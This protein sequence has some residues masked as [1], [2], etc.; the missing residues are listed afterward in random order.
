MIRPQIL[1]R[2]LTCSINHIPGPWHTRFVNY[3]LKYHVLIGRRMHYVH[4]LH[5]QYGPFVRISPT[6]VAIADPESFIAIHKIGSG[7]IKGP[8][9]SEVMAG[10]EPG[11]VFITDPKEHVV[12]RKLLARAFTSNSLR[13]NWEPVVREKVEMAVYRIRADALK[14]KADILKWWMLMTT[15][16]IAHLSFGESFKTLEF[17]QENS[18]IHALESL[19]TSSMFRREVPL[20][21]YLAQYLP[22][23]Y[24]KQLANAGRI[25]G[26]YAN[27]ATS[28]QQRNGHSAN[29]FS[30][31]QAAC[32]EKEKSNLTPEKIQSEATN[33][34]VAGSDTTSI[35]LTYLVWVVLKRPALR[36]RLEAELDNLRDDELND[37][38]LEKLLLLNAVIEE[39]LR[40]YGAVAGNLPRSV[41]SGGVTLGGFFIPDGTVVE[42]QAYTLHRNPN[43]FPDPER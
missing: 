17:G 28:N 18:Y 1:F 10:S 7:F 11:I 35:T 16:V 6:E 27:M 23:Q 2:G 40:V 34:I 22:F 12:R 5:Q 42:T 9:Y 15:D 25:I 19:F 32:D 8:W 20:L 39:T 14:G 37:A 31:M 13:E 29:L 30:N 38:T 4:S 33:L 43:V 26:Q 3:A 36:Q 21:F 24:P 41:P